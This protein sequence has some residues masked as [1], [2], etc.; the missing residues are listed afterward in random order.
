MYDFSTEEVLL[1]H[2]H[3]SY[4]ST[5]PPLP[6]DVA[7]NIIEGELVTEQILAHR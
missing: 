4:F 1:C 2:T 7:F 6:F 5:D 3:L